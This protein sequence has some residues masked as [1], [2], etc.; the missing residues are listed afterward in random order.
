MIVGI[1]YLNKN[2]AVYLTMSEENHVSLQCN[3]MFE[4]DGHFKL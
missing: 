4:K 2:S 3:A 1:W